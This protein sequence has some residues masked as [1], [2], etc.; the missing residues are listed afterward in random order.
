MLKLKF[1]IRED[2]NIRHPDDKRKK[3]DRYIKEYVDDDGNCY[4]KA[5]FTRPGVK[6]KVPVKGF[7]EELNKLRNQLEEDVFNEKL[8]VQE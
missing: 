1:H 7:H 6:P 5:F 8:C 4:R 2:Y 3:C